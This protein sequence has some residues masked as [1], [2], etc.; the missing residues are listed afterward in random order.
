MGVRCKSCP[1][2]GKNLLLR[3]HRIVY[4]TLYDSPT[5]VEAAAHQLKASPDSPKLPAFQLWDQSS[6]SWARGVWRKAE[7]SSC[8]GF[9]I[10]THASTNAIAPRIWHRRALSR[11]VS[12]SGAQAS[13]SS[14]TGTKAFGTASWA[15]SY[16]YAHPHTC[17]P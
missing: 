16:V 6:S 7:T 13:F 17:A 5:H 8:R 11:R 14:I 10:G 15:L 3:M 4:R 2:L 1:G 12:K 9:L